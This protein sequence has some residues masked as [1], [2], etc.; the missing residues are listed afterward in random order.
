MSAR[1][2]V[3]FPVLNEEAMLASSIERTI[4][5]CNQHKVEIH[6]FCIADNGS[7]DRTPEIG[8]MLAA[9][10][11]NLRYL[12]V[13]KR[14]F[15]LALKTAWDATDADFVGYMDV[16]LATDLRHLKEVSEHIACGDGY[17]LYLGSRLKSG[18]SVRNRT[19]LRELTSRMFNQLLRMRLGVSFS[20]AMC[21]FKFIDRNLYRRLTEQFAFTDDWFFAT[22][23]A[24]RAEWLGAKIL[25]MPVDWTDQPDSKSSAR[26]VNLSMLYLAGI[27]ELRREKRQLKVSPPSTLKAR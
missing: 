10:Y 17:Q 27:A 15:G 11:P 12:R 6:E 25:D 21:G 7:T 24:V 13:G 4:A 9:R 8:E 26:L 22:Q 19:L 20:D 2:Q 14:G 16:D 3:T 18:A 23:L 5:F 1:I